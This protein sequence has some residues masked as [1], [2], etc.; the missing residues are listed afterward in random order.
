MNTMAGI[1]MIALSSTAMSETVLE[2]NNYEPI[3]KGA[4]VAAGCKVIV[5]AVNNNRDIA[6]AVA[7]G[8]IGG[9]SSLRSLAGIAIGAYMSRPSGSG[10][11]GP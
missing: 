3:P 4:D 6:G 9:G 10:R 5:D 2:R 8:I 7:G 1:L 11:T